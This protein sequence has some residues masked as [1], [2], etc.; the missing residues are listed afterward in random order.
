MAQR[1]PAVPAGGCERGD[2]DCAGD[3][4]DRAK[5]GGRV[6]EGKRFF[7]EKKKQKTFIRL[8]WEGTGETGERLS[9]GDRLRP[10]PVGGRI[11]NLG[12][13]WDKSAI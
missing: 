5:P 7:F 4:G 3:G 12:R 8:A 2:P 13:K 6:R 9:D 1:A 10:S 11:D